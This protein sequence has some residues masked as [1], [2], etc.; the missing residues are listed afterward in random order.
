M[1]YT[2]FRGRS[3]TKKKKKGGGGT[4]LESSI[5]LGRSGAW[6]KFDHKKT[7]FK[8][9]SLNRLTDRVFIVSGNLRQK[10]PL[11]STPEFKIQIN[12]NYRSLQINEIIKSV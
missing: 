3:Q 1:L 2:N 4:E 5:L 7:S 12:Q 9:K 10:H 6:G 11:G 8:F